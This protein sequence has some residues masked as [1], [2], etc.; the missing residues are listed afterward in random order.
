VLGEMLSLADVEAAAGDD[1]A[2]SQRYKRALVALNG[3]KAV[4]LLV[5]VARQPPPAAVAARIAALR[6]DPVP[7]VR[8]AATALAAKIERLSPTVSLSP[9]Q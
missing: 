6:Q 1:A 5:D 2:Q 9:E 8:T 7:D 3:L 4:G